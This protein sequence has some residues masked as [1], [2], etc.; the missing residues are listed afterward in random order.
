MKSIKELSHKRRMTELLPKSIQWKD[1]VPLNRNQ[2]EMI[3]EVPEKISNENGR[4][5]I[6]NIEKNVN[7]SISFK[8]HRVS[9]RLGDN[10]IYSV[11]KQRPA[12]GMYGGSIRNSGRQRFFI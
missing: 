10:S 8:S 1:G 7:E 12:S 3:E 6:G 4:Q 11:S 9:V 5:S 2:L